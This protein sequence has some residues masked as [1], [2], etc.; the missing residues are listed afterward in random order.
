MKH[1][2]GLNIYSVTATC[3]G[4]WINIQT[5]VALDGNPEAD[6]VHATGCKQ[7]ALRLYET[8]AICLPGSF[9]EYDYGFANA[10]KYGNLRPPDYNLAAISSFISL[11]AGANDWLS[12]PEVSCNT[13]W[14]YLL[15]CSALVHFNTTSVRQ[16][17]LVG[18]WK[19]WHEP[20]CKA[21]LALV[22]WCLYSFRQDCAIRTH[23]KQK[24]TDWKHLNFSVIRE[25]VQSL[26]LGL[27][28]VPSWGCFFCKLHGRS[29]LTSTVWLRK[30]KLW[31]FRLN[32]KIWSG[33]VSGWIGT[34]RLQHGFF[35]PLAIFQGAHRFETCM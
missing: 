8:N 24:L 3:S 9:R 10:Y 2:T 6:L 35:A 11:I 25:I 23:N 17:D 27:C 21:L 7:P 12:S 34:N 29:S 26:V 30:Q 32:R 1:N 22:Q 31:A 5:S 15:K 13:C 20:R 16:C 28:Q 19:E 18:S 14:Q 33:V 4:Y